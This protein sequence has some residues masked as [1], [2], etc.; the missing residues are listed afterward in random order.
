MGVSK[1]LLAD[2]DR[3]YGNALATAL[4][5]MHNE[6]EIS[7]ITL[8]TEKNKKPDLT[9]PFDEY[10]LILLGGYP[11]EIAESICRKRK[12]KAGIVI[13][14]EEIVDSLTEQ[15]KN[16]ED[17]FRYLYKY[18]NLND[19][20]SDLNYL[21]G[22]V[23]GKKSLARKS[24]TPELIGFYGISGGTGKSVI[25]LGISREL[26]R[27]H[28][29]KVL[30]LSFEDMPAIEL[31]VGNHVQSRN[32]GD[33]LYHLFEKKDSDLCSRPASF[34][35]ADHYGV[36]TFY[37]T[38]GRNDLS[39]L[40]QQ[41]LIHLLKILSESCRYDYIIL[42][43][44]S[45]L[46]DDT[47]FLASQCGKIVLVQNDDPVSALKTKKLA[48]YLGQTSF[49]GLI[50]R[51]LLAVNR[52]SGCEYDQEEHRDNISAP[53][54]KFC[55]ENDVN[56]F[57]YASGQMDIDISHAFGVGIKRIADELT[58]QISEGERAQCTENSVR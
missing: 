26:S 34:T 42:D 54:K 45:D 39:Y 8:E 24:F 38:S 52:S 20:I 58:L 21:A 22:S 51:M 10:D 36:E 57:R 5:N 29:K 18:S 12:K 17:H 28:D 33:F 47:L 49:G 6:F 41:E 46:S 48:V 19:I 27:F 25:A 11:E 13:L 37:P 23:A 53:M 50:D 7:L 31:Y 55:I 15:F 14:T 9:I 43:L 4:S 56:S 32:I 3:E 1:I 16:E 40:T 2:K 35:T 44:K 30:Y